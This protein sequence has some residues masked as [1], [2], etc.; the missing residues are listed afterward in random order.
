MKKSILYIVL[1]GLISLI[2]QAR[3]ENT[4]ADFISALRNCEKYSQVGIVTKQGIP[5][6][7]TI[8]LEKSK[9]RCIYK[10]KISQGN[11]FQMLTC[12]FEKLQLQPLAD[13]MEKFTNLYKKE[14]SKNKI[15]EAKLTN[16][17]EIF[18]NYLINPNYC[19]VTNSVK[20]KKMK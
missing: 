18:E 8:N 3:A 6:T 16:N 4:Q 17:G 5:Y 19:K 2:S 10:E 12:N 14:I 7:I 15:F 20:T 1:L 13:S 9:D 11:G